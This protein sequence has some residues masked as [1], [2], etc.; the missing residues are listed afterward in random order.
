MNNKLTVGGIFCDL[1]LTYVSALD[2][3]L[4]WLIYVTQSL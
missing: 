2:Y 4:T 1:E 3:V